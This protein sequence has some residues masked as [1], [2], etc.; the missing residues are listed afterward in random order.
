MTDV[1]F[2]RANGTKAFFGG[3][4][5]KGIGECVDLY[6]ISQLGCCPMCLDILKVFDVDV[7]SS[8]DHFLQLAL[9]LE[10]GNGYS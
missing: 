4:F 3:E 5:L 6:R 2:Q 8:I 7:M 1:G 9:R 10:T